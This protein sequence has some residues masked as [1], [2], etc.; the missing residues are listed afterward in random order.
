M[1]P[2]YIKSREKYGASDV[3]AVLAETE[4]IRKAVK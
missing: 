3:E 2:V 4:A 1:E